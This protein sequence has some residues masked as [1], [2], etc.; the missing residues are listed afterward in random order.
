MNQNTCEN[1]TAAVKELRTLKSRVDLALDKFEP[2]DGMAGMK[3][4][5]GLIEIYR[6][7][8]LTDLLKPEVYDFLVESVGGEEELYSRFRTFTTTGMSNV[9]VMLQLE[10]EGVKI[11]DGAHGILMNY[12]HGRT[13]P[14]LKVPTLLLKV[15]ELFPTDKDYSL[16]YLT[17]LGN[18]YQRANEF[19]LGYLPQ[20]ISADLLLSNKDLLEKYRSIT[21]YCEAII[22]KKDSPKRLT[23]GYKNGD[24]ILDSSNCAE[25]YYMELDDIFIFSI[26]SSVK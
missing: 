12:G 11:T 6:N 13:K 1:L 3:D 24:I 16:A 8:V 26:D 17:R 15:K 10:A 22:M 7:R 23:A 20:E 18:I 9:D 14:N 21:P 2:N 4:A 25:I 5:I 19:G